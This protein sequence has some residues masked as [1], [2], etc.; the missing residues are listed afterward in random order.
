MPSARAAGPGALSTASSGRS[1]RVLVA[2]GLD[3]SAAS[4]AQPRRAPIVIVIFPKTIAGSA[5]ST[6]NARVREAAKEEPERSDPPSGT[7]TTRPPSG[8]VSS[9]A[10]M[11]G[12]ASASLDPVDANKS[13]GARRRGASSPQR[14]RQESKAD[15]KG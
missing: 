11:P 1:G 5:S 6:I 12:T 13:P 9:Q 3:E 14:H 8:I 7:G 10:V 4:A 2:L 15:L